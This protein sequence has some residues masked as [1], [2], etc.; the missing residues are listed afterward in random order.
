[1][2]VLLVADM[3]WWM[4]SVAQSCP[5][6][7]DPKNRSP[8]G[9]SVHGISQARILEWAALPFFRGSSPLRSNLCLLYLCVGR[10]PLCHCATREARSRGWA[11][12]NPQ[13]RMTYPVFTS[14]PLLWRPQDQSGDGERRRK[15]ILP[16]S[17]EI[18]K[19]SGPKTWNND[20][21]SWS[22]SSSL[23]FLRN[24]SFCPWWL[25]ISLPCPGSRSLPKMHKL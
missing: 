10:W 3:G 12:P 6:L 16:S 24:E 14:L 21:N 4:C 11:L 22:Q 5:T 9:C 8:P 1:M 19:S 13:T 2:S 25:W 23:S 20:C 18:F 7:C 15:E 17:G